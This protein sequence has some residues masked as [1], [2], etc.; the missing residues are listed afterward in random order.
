[1]LAFVIGLVLTL[2]SPVEP[3]ATLLPA[4]AALAVLVAAPGGRA[5]WVGWL[6]VGVIWGAAALAIMHEARPPRTLA[7]RDVSVTGSIVGLVEGDEERTR[8]LLHPETIEPYPEGHRLP[9]L[10]RLNWYGADKDVSAGQRWRFPIR[11]ERPRGLLNPVPFDY[12][13][14]LAANRIDAEGYVRDDAAAHRLAAAGAVEGVRSWLAD[15]L[16]QHT[17]AHSGSAVLRAITVGDRRGF[18]D[19]LWEIF[20]STGTAH[21]VAISGLHIGLAAGVGWLVGGRLV[22]LWPWLHRRVPSRFVGA[23]MAVTIGA[24]YAQLAGWSMPTVRALTM[25]ILVVGGVLARRWWSPWRIGVTAMAGLAAVDP[26][27]LLAPGFW[28]SFGAVGLILI[29]MHGLP[30]ATSRI[31]VLVR[32]QALL[33]AGMGI[34][35]LVFFGQAAWLSLPV[36]LIAVPVFSLVLVPAALVSAVVVALL[37]GTTVAGM[38]AGA[39]A[40]G[41]EAAVRGLAVASETAGPIEPGP[42]V[43]LAAALAVALA[44]LLLRGVVPLPA[45]AFVAAGLLIPPP[46]PASDPLRVQILEVGQ[47]LSVVVETPEHTLVYDTGPAWGDTAAARFSLLPYLREHGRT[48]IDD[49]IISHRDEDHA[50]GRSLLASETTIERVFA[51]GA[52]A[53]G[54]RRCEAG[55]RWRRGGVTFRFLWPPPG[56]DETG[57]AGSCV[58]L[59]TFA[60]QRILITGDIGRAQE[61]RVR[62]RLR[63]PVDVLVV[64][65]HGSDDASSEAFVAATRPELAVIATGYGNAYGLPDDRVVTRYRC[66][67]ARVLT[68]AIHGAISL[69]FDRT[70][71]WRHESRRRDARRFYHEGLRRPA[72]HGPELI[73]YDPRRTGIPACR[74]GTR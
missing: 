68:T 34:L 30:I 52:P 24:V 7:P 31:G 47:G 4:V 10:I 55:Y 53:S 1:M 61:A 72:F 27:G 43:A 37:P 60:D 45:S 69:R 59:V 6:G 33:A 9:H 39:V 36:N 67:G 51:G 70:G 3:G 29:A 46:G 65:H 21:L 15:R 54:S 17:V 8:F 11:L 74:T 22:R 19:E 49:L 66:R 71:Q 56:S 5:R 64:P 42:G 13:R 41:L 14:Y 25:L 12:E 57:N 18:D 35:T 48:R 16:Q 40:H 23:L 58:L 73:E 32:L 28:L 50:G 26:W 62:E 20:R 44:G 38:I 63:G 2:N